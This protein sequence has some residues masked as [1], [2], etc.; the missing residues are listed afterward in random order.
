MKVKG[1]GQTD[2]GLK[3][4]TNE[5]S[6]VV[7][8]ELDLFIVCDG[9][10]G[11]NAGEVASA[12]TVRLVQQYIR[13]NR[14]VV[15]R[16]ARED[17]P[18]HREAVSELV[19]DAINVA[20]SEVFKM[21]QADKGKSGMATTIVLFLRAGKKAVIANVGDSRIYQARADRAYQL[22][23]DHAIIAEQIRKGLLKP[24]EAGKYGKSDSI[25]R[26]VG[27]QE[28]VEVDTLHI[29]LAPGDL[30]LL[31]S[32]GLC[33]YFKEPQDFS[34]FAKKAK[35]PDLSKELVTFARA[36][37]G[38]DNITAIVVHVEAESATKTNESEAMPK[39]ELIQKI[40]LFRYLT[41]Q[42][43]MKVLA[44]ASVRSYMPND[45]IIVENSLGN[46]MFVILSGSV[47]LLKSGQMI[48]PL[49]PGAFF[50]EMGLID[51]APRSASIV[52]AEPT[53]LMVI[54]RADFYP[55][56]RKEPNLAVKLLWSF[57]QS[58]NE[59]LRITTEL[60]SDVKADLDSLKPEAPFVVAKED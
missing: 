38:K 48:R 6:F 43:L 23:E 3:R 29:D 41:Y 24:E 36:Q 13:K 59:R 20:C 9:V 49:K 52:A 37:G 31:C 19:S 54:G 44:V 5:D 45:P 10:G 1:Y 7:D 30:Y 35:L 55:L 28:G 12:N 18:A 47:S 42:E 22:T 46:E 33:D 26:A 58:L 53:R 39:P 14:A 11:H 4:S 21:A 50:G 51:N 34:T 60:L 17:I 27:F 16:Y 40:P 32:D 25:T 15:D 2:V 56:L 8:P 57:C